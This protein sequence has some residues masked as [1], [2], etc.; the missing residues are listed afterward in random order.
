M[1][2]SLKKSNEDR[3]KSLQELKSMEAEVRKIENQFSDKQRH[4]EQMR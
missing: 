3:L 4:I 2:E 1:E